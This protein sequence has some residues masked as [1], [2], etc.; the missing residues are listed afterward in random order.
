M[1]II[2]TIDGKKLIDEA[3]SNTLFEVE[4]LPGIYTVEL[5][6]NY[7]AARKSW[8]SVPKSIQFTTEAGHIYETIIFVGS[9]SGYMNS[10]STVTEYNW[11]PEI[12]DVDISDIITR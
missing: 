8:S 9:P 11:Y 2:W 7:N 10:F 1:S 12:K 5:Y 6:I 4:L 3:V